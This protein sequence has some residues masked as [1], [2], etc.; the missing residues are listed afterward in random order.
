MTTNSIRMNAMTFWREL[1]GP[2]SPDDGGIQHLRALFGT[3]MRE[4]ALYVAKSQDDVQLMVIETD[5][6]VYGC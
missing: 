1:C 2:T 4:N 6:E 5:C 3:D